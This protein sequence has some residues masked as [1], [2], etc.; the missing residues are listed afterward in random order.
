VTRPDPHAGFRRERH[1]GFELEID[2]LEEPAD[3]FAQ[4]VVRGLSDHPRWLHCRWL[5]DDAGSELFERICEQPEY[6]QTR[7]EA[8]LLREHAPALRELTRASTVVELGSGSSVKTRHLLRAWGEGRYVPVDIS[9]GILRR[10]CAGLAAEYPRIAVRGIAA[11]YERAFPLLRELSPLVLL[12]LGSTIG[13]LNPQ[14]TADFLDRVSASLSPGDHFVVGIDLVKDVRTLEAAYNDAAGWSAGFTKNLFA[15]MNRE[16]GTRLDL[17][18]IE[19]VAYYCHELDQ[20]EIYARFVREQTV[21]LP[22]IGRRF[23]IARGEMINT[24]ISRKFQV[25]EL[26]ANA[27][28]FGL[29]LAASFTDPT[30]AFAVLVLR[31]RNRRP[32]TAGREMSA[33][34]HL[35]SARARTLELVEPLTDEQLEQQHVPILSPIVWDL[36]HIANFEEQWSI[37][38][39]DPAAPVE[40]WRDHLYDPIANPRPTRRRLPLPDRDGTLR[41]MQDVRAGVRRRLAHATFDPSDPLLADGYVYKMIAQHEAQHTETMLQTIQLIDDLAYEPGRRAEP[42]T[43]AAAVDAPYAVIPAGPFVMGTDDRSFAYDNERPAHVVESAR[44]RIDLA[45]VTNGQYL[46]FML[47]GGYRRRELWTDEGWLWLADARVGHPAQ[48]CRLADDV[49]GERSFGRI[50]PLFLDRPVMHVSWYEAAAYASWAGKRLPTEAEW[51]KAAAW[52]LETRVA[53][54]YPWGD[55]PPTDDHA[56][57]DQRSFAPAA[58]GA[59]PRGRSFFGCHQMIGDVWEWTASDFGPYPGFVAFPYREYSEVHFGRGYKVLRGGSWAT[60]P[61]A[62][63]NTF[64]NWDLPQRRQIFAGFRCA[65]DG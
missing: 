53:R 12:F 50:A 62:V 58:V 61:I 52:D 43:V 13:N 49:W 14:E 28:R 17:D 21:A 47:D 42:R 2:S 25:D 36:G 51:E 20:I 10:S 64:R 15:R 31:V 48:W 45:P 24:E 6:Y 41:Y 57:L 9:L 29:E 59:Y 39:L 19:H 40:A 34:T 63:R 56:N 5:Y 11:S 54:R 35:A 3:G 18:A 16:L 4:S 46:S 32:V 23:R 33:G 1:R 27:A 8:A 38:A 7:T 30:K 22:D 37:R 65:E 44:Y 60:R 55:A 26:A